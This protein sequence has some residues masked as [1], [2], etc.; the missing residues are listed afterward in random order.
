MILKQIMKNEE[1]GLHGLGRLI[2]GLAPSSA[3]ENI[4]GINF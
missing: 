4:R 3:L 2:I 1:L